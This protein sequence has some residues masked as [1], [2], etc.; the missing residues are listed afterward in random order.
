MTHPSNR[1][2]RSAQWDRM[3]NDDSYRHNNQ[4]GAHAAERVRD[5]T[6]TEQAVEVYVCSKCSLPVMPINGMWQHSEA[7]D[8]VFCALFY[9]N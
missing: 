7:A 3:N 5:A 1:D 9:G 2:N 4:D 6:E 8:A